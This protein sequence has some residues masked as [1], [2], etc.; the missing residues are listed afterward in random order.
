VAA[1]VHVHRRKFDVQQFDDLPR[2]HGSRVLTLAI[3][4]RIAVVLHRG[5]QDFDIAG[6]HLEAGEGWLRLAFPG[7]WLHEHPLTE[8]DLAREKTYLKAAG[9]DLSFS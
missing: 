3:L 8:A 9:F 2:R 5:R 1:L 4:L 7:K 6:I